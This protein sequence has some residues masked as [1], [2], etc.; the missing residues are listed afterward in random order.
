[1][2]LHYMVYVI[3]IDPFYDNCNQYYTHIYTIDRSPD[4]PL[5]SITKRVQLPR[6]SPFQPA[7]GSVRECRIAL[8]DPETPGRLLRPGQE[9]LL[10]TYL[11]AHGYEIDPSVTKALARSPT[12]F[13]R[14]LCA[15]A[16]RAK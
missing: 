9:A 1:M 2:C 13:Q 4:L 6:L 5:A 12:G 3:S 7:R 8:C 10:F 15:I 11:S 16:K 14:V